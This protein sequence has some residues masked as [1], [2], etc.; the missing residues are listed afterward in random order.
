MVRTTSGKRP[1][2]WSARAAADELARR[3]VRL[4]DGSIMTRDRAERIVAIAGTFGVK[5][6]PTARGYITVTLA[7]RGY[8]IEG[9]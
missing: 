8:T 6:E 5:A 9:E 2:T 4:P 3:Q 7:G 1:E